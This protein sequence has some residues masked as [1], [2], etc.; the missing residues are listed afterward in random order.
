MR[1]GPVRQQSV[2][3]LRLQGTAK[4]VQTSLL[5]GLSLGSR[6]ACRKTGVDRFGWKQRL[7]LLCRAHY[8]A[9][10]AQYLPAAVGI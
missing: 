5:G 1:V 2:P 9:G 7:V 3:L 10:T 4:Q 6:K 8:S